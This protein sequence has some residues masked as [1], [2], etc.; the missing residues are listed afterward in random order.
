MVTLLVKNNFVLSLFS[1]EGHGLVEEPSD[2][3]FFDG[4]VDFVVDELCSRTQQRPFRSFEFPA[5]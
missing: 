3:G 1:L 2:S 5:L 4:I